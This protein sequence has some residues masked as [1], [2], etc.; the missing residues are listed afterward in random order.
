MERLTASALA[1]MLLTAALTFF[2]IAF[3]VLP[4][5]GAIWEHRHSAIFSASGSPSRRKKMPKE[6]RR[7]AG[8]VGSQRHS[9]MNKYVATIGS[10]A[11]EDG[12]LNVVVS[13]GPTTLA[14]LTA[15]TPDEAERI[16]DDI[17]RRFRKY[18][19]NWPWMRL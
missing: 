1:S 10:A 8:S 3:L 16:C 7:S 18:E 17:V 19:L 15:S 4:S 14:I 9:N 13:N 6:F 5:G 11:R 2:S 12:K